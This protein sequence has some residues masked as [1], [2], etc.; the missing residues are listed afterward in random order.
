MAGRVAG[1][2]N[3]IAIQNCIVTG[4]MG[5][6]QALGT[7]AGR[8]GRWASKQQAG[9]RRTRHWARARAASERQQAQA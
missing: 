7:G 9:A 1:G 6:R 3:H 4:G 8:A 5:A 2:K